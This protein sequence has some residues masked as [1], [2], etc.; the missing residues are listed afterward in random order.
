MA[1]DPKCRGGGCLVNPDTPLPDDPRIYF[2]ESDRYIIGCNRVFCSRCHEFVR[3]WP[4]Y[5][6][7]HGS[8]S[9]TPA[10]RQELFETLDPDQ[11]PHLVKSKRDRV[12]ACK[13]W[14]DS[15]AGMEDLGSGYFDWD[16]WHCGGHPQ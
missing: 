12:Y 6:L 4:G 5:R 8:W 14:A 2:K 10:D 16:D 11:S 15:I 7:A 9:L 3:Q 13:C 1:M